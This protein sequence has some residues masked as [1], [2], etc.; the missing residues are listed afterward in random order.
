MPN[1]KVI[2]QDFFKIKHNKSE[3]E[4]ERKR[5]RERGGEGGVVLLDKMNCQRRHEWVFKG[6]VPF[7]ERQDIVL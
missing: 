3:R 4:R 5:E 2:Q 1:W 7:V 6:C